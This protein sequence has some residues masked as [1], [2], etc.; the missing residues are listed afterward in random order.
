MEVTEGHFDKGT[1][2][3]SLKNKWTGV[4]GTRG[5]VFPVEGTAW[6][7]PESVQWWGVRGVCTRGPGGASGPEGS[8]LQSL[9][10]C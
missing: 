7:K 10:G 6:A 8:D 2:W 9:V 3:W 5:R 4:G 1:C